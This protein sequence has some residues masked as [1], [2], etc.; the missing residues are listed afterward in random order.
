[1]KIGNM[2]L[3]LMG[4]SNILVRRKFRWYITYVLGPKVISGFV[5]VSVRPRPDECLAEPG[6]LC[7][8]NYWLGSDLD[9]KR[10]ILV[11]HLGDMPKDMHE[12]LY[13]YFAKTWEAN[14]KGDPKPPK[15]ELSLVLYD[16]CGTP[17][18]TWHIHGATPVQINF[19]DLSYNGDEMLEVEWKYD[20]VDYENNLEET[21]I[22]YLSDKYWIP[23]KVKWERS[24]EPFD[25]GQ[26]S[27]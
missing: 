2:G 25:F 14:T 5:K 18:E 19:G 27:K 1:M 24:M 26:G 11:T 4:N 16:G 21:E 10:R 20:S 8:K 22:N 9:E 13:E 12:P 15:I 7:T 3:G 17:L 6:E 23:G